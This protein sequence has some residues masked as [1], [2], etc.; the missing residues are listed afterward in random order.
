MKKNDRLFHGMKI[1]A[2]QTDLEPVK[3]RAKPW[4]PVSPDHRV[5]DREQY[6]EANNALRFIDTVIVRV[7]CRF[8]DPSVGGQLKRKMD[9][10]TKGFMFWQYEG[11]FKSASQAMVYVLYLPWT[12]D[13]QS[14]L[15]LQFSIPKVLLGNNYETIPAGFDVIARLNEELTPIFDQLG[16]SSMDV[17]QLEVRR[18]DFS[19]NFQVGSLVQKYLS[20]IGTRTVPHRSRS[21]HYNDRNRPAGMDM[22]DNGMCFYSASV[23]TTLYDKEKECKNPLAAGLLRLEISLRKAVAVRKAFG[24][25][26]PRLIDLNINIRQKIFFTEMTK[27]GLTNEIVSKAN[28]WDVLQQSFSPCQANHLMGFISLERQYPGLSPKDL[29]KVSGLSEQAIRSYRRSLREAGVSYML[30]EEITLPGLSLDMLEDPITHACD[31]W[32]PA[33]TMAT[34]DNNRTEV[35]RNTYSGTAITIV[36]PETTSSIPLPDDMDDVGRGSIPEPPGWDVSCLHGADRKQS[37]LPAAGG[38]PGLII[39]GS[40]SM[41]KC[42]IT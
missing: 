32:D 27:L 34:D 12:G 10:K 30:E 39:D 24:M 4:L 19:L 41:R 2:Q 15:S 7:P 6:W 38:Q 8:P 28:L 25:E 33:S 29:A 9:E 3:R 5:I 17:S 21:T 20:Y 14:Y 13:K 11:E 40:S 18:I 22:H 35:P 42:D 31:R 36:T 1:K 26:H 16:L 37:N 23:R